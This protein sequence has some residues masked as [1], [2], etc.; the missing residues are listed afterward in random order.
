M[1]DVLWTADHVA[2]ALKSLD[3]IAQ[4]LKRIATAVEGD[5]NNPVLPRLA[6]AI[7]DGVAAKTETQKAR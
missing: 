2:A 6:K 4:S 5:P 1:G 3:A 7:E